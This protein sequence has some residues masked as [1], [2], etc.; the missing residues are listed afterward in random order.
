MEG[1]ESAEVK[2]QRFS[3]LMRL[4]PVLELRFVWQVDIINLLLPLTE[5]ETY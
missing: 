5:E 3:D 1:N 2:V 4:T